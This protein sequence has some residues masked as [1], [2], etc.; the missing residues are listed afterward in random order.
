MMPFT[1]I[2]Q[3]LRRV[4][5]LVH[6]EVVVFFAVT[7]VIPRNSAAFRR[8]RNSEAL[9]QVSGEM[10][11]GIPRSAPTSSVPAFHGLTRTRRSTGM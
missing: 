6:L 9:Q 2:V 4:F 3:P 8:I 11:V 7:L 1:R 5:V 10:G